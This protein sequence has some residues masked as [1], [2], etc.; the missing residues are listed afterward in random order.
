MQLALE[1]LQQ[2]FGFSAFRGVQ[3]DVIARV[4]AGKSTLAV[5]PTGAGKSLCYQL[6]SVMH[7]GTTIV[8]SPLIALMHDQMRA[9]TA[10]G[11]RA[12]TLTSADDDRYETMERMRKREIDLLYVATKRASGPRCWR[13]KP[14]AG[15]ALPGPSCRMCCM[16]TIWRA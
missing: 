7:G 12:A 11:I 14:C 2:V 15:A 4:L 1:K 9:A 3:A 6:P 8:V 13:P 16:K 10:A 5:M